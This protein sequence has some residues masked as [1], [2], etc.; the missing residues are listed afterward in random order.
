MKKNPEKKEPQ[1]TCETAPKKELSPEEEKKIQ[2]AL[3]RAKSAFEKSNFGYAVELYLSVL[4][5]HP[6]NEEASRM[7]FPSALALRQTKGKSPMIDVA[8]MVNNLPGYVK[9]FLERAKKKYNSSLFTFLEIVRTEPRNFL[10]L[11]Q[12]GILAKC[13]GLMQLSIRSFETYSQTRPKDVYALKIL[14]QLYMDIDDRESAKTI[15]KKILKLSPFDGDA[16][17]GLKDISA[18][19]TIEKSK[20][21]DEKDYRSKIKDEDEAKVAEI[22]GHIS[23]TNEE[24]LL[25]IKKN[26]EKVLT[27]PQDMRTIR[28]LAEQYEK[29]GNNR[30]SLE[31]YKKLSALQ[32]GDSDLALYVVKMEYSILESEKKTPAELMEFNLKG[33]NA[34]CNQFPTNHRLRYEYGLR[35]LEAMKIDEAIA[36]FQRSVTA[37]S[38][39]AESMNQLGICFDRKNILDIAIDQFKSALGSV[40]E[41]NDLKKEITYNLGAVLEKSGKIPEALSYF[42]NI[43]QVDIS[44]KDVAQRI[45]K[46]YKT[47]K[48]STSTTT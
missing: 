48:G 18:K 40:T 20:W 39:K 28:T 22:E 26:E 44:Y 36:Q 10:I 16:G 46:Y 34:L 12:I 7:F 9:G 35:L 2:D 4:K 11:N 3:S 15:F 32:A 37:P 1:L 5:T 29:L 6:H 14:G 33:H 17:K 24:L 45:E 23:K 31:Y 30:N 42:K 41:M 43:Y 38:Y 19:T 25:L 8:S 21:D 13:L 47:D 27:N